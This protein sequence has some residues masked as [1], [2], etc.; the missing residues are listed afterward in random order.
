[1]HAYI[2]AYIQ[3]CTHTHTVKN[4]EHAA[5][6]SEES[7]ARACAHLLCPP[8]SAGWVSTTPSAR[9]QLPAHESMPPARQSGAPNR[10]VTRSSFGAISLARC[11]LRVRA[12][13]NSCSNRRDTCAAPSTPESPCSCASRLCQERFAGGRNLARHLT[14]ARPPARA[15]CP[16]SAHARAPWPWQ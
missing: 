1:M 12:C 10:T 3:V 13:R 6:A 4:Q 16:A 15:P 8:R 14:P 11:V 2:P 5:D 7:A 9:A